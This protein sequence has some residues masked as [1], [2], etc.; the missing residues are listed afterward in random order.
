MADA[1]KKASLKLG[2][3]VALGA[4][5]AG[6]VLL[7]LQMIFTL[8]SKSAFIET[9]TKILSIVETLVLLALLAGAVLVLL[10]T[11]KNPHLRT[12]VYAMAASAFFLEQTVAM[13]TIILGFAWP[14]FIQT[15]VLVFI[16]GAL[17]ATGMV[18][19]PSGKELHEAAS[20]LHHP[21]VGGLPPAAPPPPT[22]PAA[23]QA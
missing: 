9:S 19:L 10:M 3:W 8:A 15:A 1:A 5:A 16:A 21:P 18:A 12:L 6:V 4:G 7:L 11:L 13:Q 17:M 2:H 20:G 14:F 23:P 22:P